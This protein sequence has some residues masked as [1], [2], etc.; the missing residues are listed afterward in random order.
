M[1]NSKPTKTPYCP[2]TRLLPHDGVALSDPTEY[3][4]LV[5][6]LQY[7]TFT[8]PD[9]A[10][11]VHQLCQFMSNPTTIH[12][13]AAKRVL[14]YLCGTLYHGISFSPY[15]LTL[16]AFSNA[17]WA[18]DPYDRRSTTGLLVF[19]GPSP[20]SWSSKKQTTV[21]SSSTEA[22]YRGLATTAAEMSWLRILFKE[23]RIFLSHVPVLWCDDALAIALFAN[24]MFHSCTKHIEVDYHYVRDK[25]LRRDLCVHFVSGKDNLV[26]IFTKPLLSPSFL[27]Q[28]RK[29]LLDTSPKSLRR[30]VSD[31]GDSTSEKLKQVTNG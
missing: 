5:G 8:C 3:R 14:K 30:D 26:D 11:S 24:P 28:R 10:F 21:A 23:L 22:E 17:D 2:S 13:E 15:P 7:L 12:L 19:L 4:S 16:T 9:L 20:I 31:C 29:L 18:G 25:V 27:L 1:E 6:A